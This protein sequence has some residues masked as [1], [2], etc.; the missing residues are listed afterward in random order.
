M[1]GSYY[2]YS[3][4]GHLILFAYIKTDKKTFQELSQ[5]PS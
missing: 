3:L 5:H 2:S 4:I 1:D